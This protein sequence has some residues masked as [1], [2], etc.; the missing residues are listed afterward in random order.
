MEDGGDLAHF[1]GEL[2]KLFGEDGLHAVGK[3]L[4]GFVVNFDKQSVGTNCNGSARKR[5]NFVPLAGAVA[6]VDEDRQMAAFLYGWHDGK[7]QRV[8]GKI[9]KGS[10]APLAEHHVV[11]TF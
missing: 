5:Q 11:I 1:T 6:G 2:A 9:G 7:V 10:N 8:A 4:V 3:S